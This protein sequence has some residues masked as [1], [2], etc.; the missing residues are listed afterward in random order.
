MATH[1]G[2]IRGF[3]AWLHRRGAIP[4]DLSA[5]VL[6]PRVFKHERCPR[7]LTQSEVES[8]LSVIDRESPGGRRDYA[9]IL[10]PGR[11]RV[12]RLRSDTPAAGRH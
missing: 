9:M 2:I 3:L 7:Y 11:L 8:V 10:L 1:C 5:V 12:T 6:S 4:R